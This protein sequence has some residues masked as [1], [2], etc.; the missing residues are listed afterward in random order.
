MSDSGA[1]ILFYR[2]EILKRFPFEHLTNSF[3]FNPQL[4]ILLYQDKNLRI[5]EIP[6]DWTDAAGKSNISALNYCWTL[7]KILCR[8]R[9]NKTFRGKSG[10]ELF[11][12]QPQLINPEFEIYRP[13]FVNPGIN[14]LR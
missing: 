4:N 9:W 2:T 1:A 8:F 12:A 10:G 7:L 3:Q 5:A 13:D 6:L 14:I 11:Y